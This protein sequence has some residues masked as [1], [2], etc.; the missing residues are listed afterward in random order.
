MVSST[1]AFARGGGDN[2]VRAKLDLLVFI[3]HLRTDIIQYA[4]EKAKRT[5]LW[6][7]LVMFG[8]E[9]DFLPFTGLDIEVRE[10]RWAGNMEIAFIS[11]AGRLS[12]ALFSRALLESV[13]NELGL[14]LSDAEESLGKSFKL[15]TPAENAG[16]SDKELNARQHTLEL[17]RSTYSMNKESVAYESTNLK[18]SAFHFQ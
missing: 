14:L 5:F 18:A 9:M 2:P 17:S 1:H 11:L 12:N 4:E 13:E 6:I 15:R 3:G 7:H 16:P 8:L 10:L